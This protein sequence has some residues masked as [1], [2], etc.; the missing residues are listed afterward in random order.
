MK[1]FVLILTL[2]AF[3]FIL[4][5]SL[6]EVGKGSYWTKVSHKWPS[7]THYLWWHFS[8][9]NMFISSGSTITNKPLIDTCQT[10]SAKVV[11]PKKPP[12]WSSSSIIRLTGHRWSQIIGTLTPVSVLASSPLHLPFPACLCWQN[13]NLAPISALHWQAVWGKWDNKKE[14][15]PYLAHQALVWDNGPVQFQE[16]NI[17]LTCGIRILLH[18]PLYAFIN[19]LKWRA[20]TVCGLLSSKCH[21]K[22]KNSTPDVSWK[23]VHLCYDHN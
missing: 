10:L 21:G 16:A 20:L 4:R 19:L 6:L 1:G 8:H 9:S 15:Q 7:Q 18:K 5:N 11:P 3:T 2:W 13:G 22:Q 17:K 14:L 23:R 12:N